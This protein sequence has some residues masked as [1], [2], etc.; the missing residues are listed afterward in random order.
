MPLEVIEDRAEV[1][2][3]AGTGGSV[4]IPVCRLDEG[5]V[6]LCPIGPSSERMEDG[7]SATGGHPET[8]P[9]PTRHPRC[10]IEVSVRRLDQRR[11]RL[12]APAF[13]A[14]E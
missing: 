7:H 1:R 6:R 5:R 3:A 11:A 10:P 8:V 9:K 4:E 13:G 14:N 2:G 12:I